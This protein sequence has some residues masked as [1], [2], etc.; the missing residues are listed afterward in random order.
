[1]RARRRAVRVLRVPLPAHRPRAR[2]ALAARPGDGLLPERR[3]EPASYTWRVIAPPLEPTIELAPPDPSIGNHH[4]FTFSST[5]PNATFECRITPNPFQQQPVR[6]LPVAAHLLQPAGRRVPVRGPRRQRVRHRRRDPGRVQLRGRQPARHD[7]P[8][9]ARAARS[10]AAPPRSPSPPASPAPTFECSLD[11]D[12]FIECLSPAH[13]PR[14]RE[15]RFPEL[16]PRHPHLHG[17]GRSTSTATSTRRPRSSPGRSS[18]RPS[19]RRRSSPGRPIRRPPRAPASR[20]PR[21]RRL[22]LRVLAR[23]R[24]LRGLRLDRGVQRPRPRQP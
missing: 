4:T 9:R 13:V 6:A 20:S 19:R 22:D 2:R 10:R 24:R 8:R 3:A 7:D 23:R 16:A 14:R 21:R 18:S 12:D 1:M 17:P 11:G 5:E 15:C